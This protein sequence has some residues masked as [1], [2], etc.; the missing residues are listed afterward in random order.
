MKVVVLD[1]PPLLH[2][3]DQTE[4]SE[5][6]KALQVVTRAFSDLRSMSGLLS[7]ISDAVVYWTFNRAVRFCLAQPVARLVR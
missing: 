4:F 2:E 7:R 3:T 6:G 5:S 1:L